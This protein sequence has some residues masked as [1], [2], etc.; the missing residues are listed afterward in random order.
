MNPILIYTIVTN[1]YD[2]VRPARI[3]PGFDYWLFTDDPHFKVDGW[4]TKVVPKSPNPI[5]QQRQIKI[6]SCVYT[7]GYDISIYIDGNMEI[8]RDPADLL[9][10]HFHGGLLTTVHP[11]RA[12]LWAEGMEVIRKKKDLEENVNSTL[13]FAKLNGFKDDLGLFETGVMVRDKS[14]D[15]EK[16]EQKWS[17]LLKDYSHRDQLILPIA[18][19]LTGVSIHSIP[20]KIT[21]SYVKFNRGH[22]V[23]LKFRKSGQGWFSSLISRLKR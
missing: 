16:L 8:I 19:H 12:T 11:K 2:K 10:N 17:E 6:N 18:L 1:N 9:K 22:R 14:K 4:E 20:R 5:K 21:F 23:S 13:E 15:V 3:F 7:K